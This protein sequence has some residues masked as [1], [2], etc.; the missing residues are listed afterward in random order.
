MTRIDI[1]IA[2]ML[3]ESNFT[4]SEKDSWSIIDG[5]VA[6]RGKKRVL[7]SS[8]RRTEN[9]EKGKHY[10]PTKSRPTMSIHNTLPGTVQVHVL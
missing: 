10:V 7:H 8:V 9:G 3:P 2:A 4:D 5:I 1:S 6:R